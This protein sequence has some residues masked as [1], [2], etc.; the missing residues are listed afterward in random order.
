MNQGNELQATLHTDTW[1]VGIPAATMTGA[2][3]FSCHRTESRHGAFVRLWLACLLLVG[4][5]FAA[6]TMT[7]R[8]QSGTA[9]LGGQVQ[10]P[11]GALIT[12][13]QL[14]LL[15]VSTGK[16]SEAVSNQSGLFTF[17]AIQPGSYTLTTSKSGF[18]KS[19]QKG[20]TLSVGQNAAITVQLKLGDNSEVVTVQADASLV[21]TSTA[22]VSEVINESSVKELPLNGR[23]PSSLVLLTTGVTNV[24]H[25]ASNAGIASFNG[26][27]LPDQTGASAGGGRQGSTYYLLDGAPN[28]DT[29]MLLA[30]P[31][32]N[33]DA[34]QEFRVISNNFD[35]QYGFSPGA[36]VSIATKS[37]GNAFHGGAFEFIRNNDLNAGNYFSHAVDPLKRNQFGAY[38]GGPIIKNKVHFFGNYQATRM[39]TQ[40][41]TNVTYA[42]TAAMLDGDFSAVPTPLGGPFSTMNG[43]PNQVD[44]SAFSSAAVTI[45]KTALP[46]GEDPATGEVTY[47]SGAYKASY[48]EGTGRVDYT[49]NDR[50]NLMV[51]SF[52]QYYNQP[53]QS[54]D[55]NLLAVSDGQSG[56][57]FNEMASHAW[58]VSPNIVNVA[59]LFWTQEGDVSGSEATDSSGQA[60]CLQRYIQVVGPP[61]TCYL[62][63]LGVSNGFN[64]NWDI[65]NF[66]RRT[67]YGLNELLTLS[68][69]RHVI[70][71]GGNVW[72]QFSQEN[73]DYPTD[74]IVNFTG[75]VT[76]FG[77]ADFLLGDVYQFQQGAGEIASMKGWQFG[78]FA[79]DQFRVSDTLTITAGLRWDPNTPPAVTGGRGS[80][81]LPGEQS[82]MY[83][84]APLGM[85]FP[86]DPGISKAL[87]PTTYNYFDPRIGMAWHPKR[88]VKTSVRAA[89][90]LFQGPLPYSYYS[91]TSDIS[92]FSPTFTL[93][94]TAT[95]PIDFDNPW[96]NFAGTNGASPFPPFAS[97]NYVPAK[98][99]AF[100][101]PTQI[102]ATFSNNFRLGI[103]QSWNVSV[104]Q[105]LTTNL[106]LHVAYVGS[107]SYHQ[108]VAVDQNPGIYNA[109]IGGGERTTY[110]QFGAIEQLTDR[111]TASYHSAQVG[112]EKRFSHSLQF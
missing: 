75:F 71:V 36:V 11:S 108:A 89:F 8:A 110:T 50:Q 91:H 40:S 13:A 62:E 45:A 21:N 68:K 58:T 48:D 72:H 61:G 54:V 43:K 27:S 41:S 37:G 103:T 93:N 59:S 52:N 7:T 74:P 88:L 25:A 76:G 14:T 32:P 66:E 26:E 16:T 57:Y 83:P 79:Q 15:N 5:F 107:Q 12:D 22:E 111:G 94:G 98:D 73:S 70:T 42:P 44:P 34:T 38:L 1:R 87:M 31:F 112:L 46:V 20:I 106:A 104:D 4:V 35:A 55:G 30:A 19:V 97:L 9:T 102:G 18:E 33:A 81:F 64:S 60:V 24:L 2:A 29:F 109:A 17:T 85:V 47:S 49:I 92:P 65:R 6:G 28:M 95:S 101:G 86:G 84:N 99:S 77:L 90:G 3:T 63:G 10:D 67:S 51:R 56:D 80:M 39:S 96:K 53:G 82:T 23:D 69:G 100:A 105:Q 78:L